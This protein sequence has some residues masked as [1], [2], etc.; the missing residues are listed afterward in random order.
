M[1]YRVI[2]ADC[3]IDL[4]WLPPDLF[5]ANASRALK[6]R[7]PYVAVGEKGPTWVS[8]N[9]GYFGL[10]NGMGSGGREYVPGEIH[11]S[12]L[13]AAEG[14]YED[15][16]NGTRR[17][18]DPDLRIKDQDRDGVQAEV[19]FGILGAGERLNDGVAAIEMMRIYNDWLA[20]FCDS[21]PAR[22]AG[23]ASIPNHD[24]A[25]ATDEIARVVARGALRGLEVANSTD[26]KPL[27]DPDWDPLW[28]AVA[29]SG[30][31]RIVYVSC[32]PATLAR[33]LREM[34]AAGYRLMHL[35]AIDLF[36]QTSHVEVV[37][38]LERDADASDSSGNA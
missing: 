38:R 29:E 37:V 9:G 21:H 14:L 33:D 30:P 6:E 23:L 24:V 5:T 25:A 36:P 16:K 13:M 2:S 3:H 11:R 18:T 19:L 17:L 4:P 26:M 31:P 12:D 27:F 1:K 32:D 35:K 22:F 34:L 20:D 10:Q 28:R 8:R 15:G 7:M